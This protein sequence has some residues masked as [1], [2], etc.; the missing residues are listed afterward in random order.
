MSSND[1][2]VKAAQASQP[3][4]VEEVRDRIVNILIVII[5]IIG[6]PLAAI[7]VPRSLEFGFGKVQYLIYA[8]YFLVVLVAIFRRRLSFRFRAFFILIVTFITGVISLTDW[9]LAGMGLMFLMSNIFVAALI[10]KHRVGSLFT[11]AAILAMAIIAFL[12]HLGHISYNFDM[13][14]FALAPFS[15]ITAM[16]HAGL[17]GILVLVVFS[18]IEAALT[19]SIDFLSRTNQRLETEVFERE[20]AEEGLGKSEERYR[21]L[22][23]NTPVSIFEEDFSDVKAYIDELPAGDSKDF[24]EYLDEHPEVVEEC[25]KRAKIVDINLA[26][27]KMFRAKDK[28]ELLSEGLELIFTEKTLD[29]YKQA[30]AAL[31]DG[32]GTFI[33]E[34]EHKT[35][36]GSILDVMIRWSVAPGHEKTFSRV[37]VS[38]TDITERK[39]AVE[40]LS[41][42]EEMFSKA[43]HSSPNLMV[44]FDFEERRRVD[45]N[46]SFTRITGYSRGEAVGTTVNEVNFLIDPLELLR[47]LQEQGYIRDIELRIRTRDGEVRTLLASGEIIEVRGKKFALMTGEDITERKRLEEQ[48]LQSQKMEAIGRLAGGVAHD[49]NNQLTVINNVSEMLQKSLSPGD[50]RHREIEMIRMAGERSASLTRQLLTFSRKQIVEPKVL[51]LDRTVT[52]LEKML[53]RLIGEDIDMIIHVGPDLGY[54][55][56]DP[57][58]MEQVII[59]LAVNARDAMPGGGKLVIEATNVHLDEEYTKDYLA[60]TP[61]R[62]VMLAVSDT[63]HGID[64]DTIPHIFEPF[65][66]TR[67]G[68]AGTGLGL[69]TVYGIVKQFEGDIHVYSEPGAGTTFKIYLPHVEREDSELIEDE[70]EKVESIGGSETILIVEDDRGVRRMLSEILSEKGY[71]ILET[72][73]GEEAIGLCKDQKNEIDLLLTDVILPGMSGRELADECLGVRPGLK[74]LYMSGYTENSIAHHGVL[75]PGLNFLQKPFSIESLLIKLRELLERNKDN[76]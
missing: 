12:V 5:A 3:R 68:D 72:S 9:G 24:R 18:R 59:N 6:V 43:F 25:V 52:N 38:I 17:Y 46:E 20:K 41:V 49:F 65:Y 27:V 16:V 75:E 29:A 26:S 7:T 14:K 58:Q 55:R 34:T 19:D 13:E 76:P 47:P 2:Q 22:F 28:N 73:S 71:R 32:Q 54:V 45:V 60:L 70:V 42:S 62:Y 57:T 44:L 21:G 74:V 33:I 66:T 69:S 10:L 63:G 61:G 31:K 15:W 40:A 35:M 67:K 11:L 36:E 39:R 37:F 53:R 64:K 51:R 8:E 50:P 30:L 23:E 56:V 48:L 4:S 1:L